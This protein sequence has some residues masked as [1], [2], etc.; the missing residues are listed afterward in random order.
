MDPGHWAYKGEGNANLVLSYVGPDAALLGRVLRLRKATDDDLNAHSPSPFSLDYEIGFQ[1]HV[2]AP[3]LGPEY[4]APADLVEVTAAFLEEVSRHVSAARP[5]GRRSRPLD[6]SQ[7][8]AALIKDLTY[9]PRQRDGEAV[10]TIAVEIKPKW[11]FLPTSPLIAPEHEVKRRTCRYCMHQQWKAKL[12]AQKQHDGHV[13]NAFC[14][15]DLYSRDRARVRAAF[16]ALLPN[17]QNNLRLFVDGQ[18]TSL[19]S[20]QARSVLAEHFQ[21]VAANAMDVLFEH[22]TNIL[23]SDN[24]LPRLQQHQRGLDPL[25][26]EGVFPLYDAMPEHLRT[27]VPTLDEWKEIT[28]AYCS[29]ATER[30]LAVEYQPS[31][32][33]SARVI[34]EYLISATLKDCSVIITLWLE[35]AKQSPP[36]EPNESVILL[37]DSPD[38]S[39]L[40]YRIGVLDVDPKR[41]AKIPAHFLLDRDIV[42]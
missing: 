20:D 13:A 41:A 12:A 29:G 6:L 39:A 21:T 22:L 28:D 34:R 11:G 7:S 24:L 35:S 31:S 1:R 18:P 8:H 25:D 30:R 5:P 15:L 37:P 4:V 2:I 10:R 26:I 19:D 32:A 27:A 33:E 42:E 38:G 16:D 40:R 3:L 14:P 23:L 9:V 17:P 36:T